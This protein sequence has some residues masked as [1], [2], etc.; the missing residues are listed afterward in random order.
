[1]SFYQVEEDRLRVYSEKQSCALTKLL[2]SGQ[3]GIVYMTDV[4]SAVKALRFEELF[5]RE[6]KVYRR[7]KDNNVQRIGIFNIP[8]LIRAEESLQI[9]E[10]TFVPA[11]FVLD[12]AGAYVDTPPR[13]YWEPMMQ[14]TRN[15]KCS[16]YGS[17]SHH[18]NM[19]VNELRTKH[20]IF[21]SDIHLR[22]ISI[23]Q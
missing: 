23:S 12:F 7:L 15:S 16:E 6:L 2:G 5:K 10:M 3:D 8:S 22:N 1:M 17:D 13:H 9:I 4:P 14:E 21:L 11:P 18:V 19:V 20:G